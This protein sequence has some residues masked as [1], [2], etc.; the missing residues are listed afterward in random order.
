MVTANDEAQIL[1]IVE[2]WLQKN[3][4]HT[5]KITRDVNETRK[6]RNSR[7]NLDLKNYMYHPSRNREY[8]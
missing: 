1:V 3:E 2:E 5:L 6:N 7:I 8:E 4:F